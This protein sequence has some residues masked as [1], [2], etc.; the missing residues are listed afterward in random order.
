MKSFFTA[1]AVIALLFLT[2]ANAQSENFKTSVGKKV[3]ISIVR[4]PCK[5]DGTLEMTT[6]NSWMASTL[7]HGRLELGPSFQE[8]IKSGSKCSGKGAIWKR[9]MYY[10]STTKGADIVAIKFPDHGLMKWTVMVE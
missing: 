3:F 1:S 2:A 6:L 9:K 10:V 5:G 8:A 7:K 4:G